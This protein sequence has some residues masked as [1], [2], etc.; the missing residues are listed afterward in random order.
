LDVPPAVQKERILKRN[1]EAMAKRFFDEWI[2]MERLYF[3]K[4]DIKK[5]CGLTVSVE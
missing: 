2:P 3:E 5:R 1:G 4:T